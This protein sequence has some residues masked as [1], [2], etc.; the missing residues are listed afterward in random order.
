MKEE[1]GHYHVA[2]ENADGTMVSI[3]AE[4]TD[5]LNHNSIF[6]S[7]ENVSA[8]FERGS[9]GYSPNKKKFD[10]LELKTYNWKIEPLKV[11]SARSSFFENENIFPKGSAKFDNALLMTEINHEW[12]SVEQ[13]AFA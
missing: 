10:G 12:I 3:D 9:V 7:L 5:S 8:F 2:F 6:K 13:K 1:N 11:I 4:K